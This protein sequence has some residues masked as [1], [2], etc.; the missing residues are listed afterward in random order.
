MFWNPGFSG[1]MINKNVNLILRVSSSSDPLL[2]DQLKLTFSRNIPR[3]CQAL[4]VPMP[5]PFFILFY[6]ETECQFFPA[7]L[8]SGLPL[9]PIP[10]RHVGLDNMSSVVP[11][12]H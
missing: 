9:F 7:S 8:F 1:I 11:C 5:E 2:K 10:R 12:R 6:S 3:T 4:T